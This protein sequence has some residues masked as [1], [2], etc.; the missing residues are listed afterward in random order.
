MCVKCGLCKMFVSGYFSL[1]ASIEEEI[2]F[3]NLSSKIEEQIFFEYNDTG[4]KYKS[5]VRSRVS[6]L[7]DL[8]NPSFRQ[9]VINGHLL[10]SKVAVMKTDVSF[11]TNF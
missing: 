10:P 5:Q 2:K 4:M 8:K 11:I 3:Y 1:I 7:G 6:N 9:A